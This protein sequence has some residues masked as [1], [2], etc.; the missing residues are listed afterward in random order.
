[1]GLQKN[2]DRIAETFGRA[3]IGIHNKTSVRFMFSC[4]LLTYRQEWSS[5][6]HD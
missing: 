2:V 6:R 1:M 3:V 4:T 5:G